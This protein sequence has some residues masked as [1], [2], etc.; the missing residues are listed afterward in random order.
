MIENELYDGDDLR[1]LDIGVAS[2][3]AALSA[4]RCIPFTSCNAGT[5]GGSH[6]ETYPL[7]GSFARAQQSSCCCAR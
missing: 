5:F 1:G 7:V 2:A 3:V 6:A 4:A